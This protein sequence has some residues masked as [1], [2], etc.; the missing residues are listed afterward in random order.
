MIYVIFQRKQHPNIL[1]L[2]GCSA[3]IAWMLVLYLILS[4]PNN[5]IPIE[6]A[7]HMPSLSWQS[8]AGVAFLCKTHTHKPASMETQVVSTELCHVVHSNVSSP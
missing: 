3:H 7:E 2:F 5:A 1:G 6:P 4:Y 8:N